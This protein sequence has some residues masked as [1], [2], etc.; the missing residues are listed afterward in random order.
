VSDISKL[1]ADAL[2]RACVSGGELEELVCRSSENN[3]KRK[4]IFN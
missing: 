2:V 1:G 3:K 4:T